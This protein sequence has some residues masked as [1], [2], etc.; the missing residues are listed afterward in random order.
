MMGASGGPKWVCFCALLQLFGFVSLFHSANPIGVILIPRNYD[1]WARAAFNIEVLVTGSWLEH[2]GKQV[3]IMRSQPARDA[4]VE[5]PF[6]VADQLTAFDLIT[7]FHRDQTL[8][9]RFDRI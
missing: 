5:C 3:P 9:V 7:E 8:P 6:R 2:T 1:D 4:P